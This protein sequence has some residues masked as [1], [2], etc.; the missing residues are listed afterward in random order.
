MDAN[1][2]NV[3]KHAQNDTKHF[4]NEVLSG[5]LSENGEGQDYM[6]NISGYLGDINEEIIDTEN[7]IA[8]NCCGHYKL[9][10]NEEFKTWRPFGRKDYQLLYVAGGSADFYFDEQKVTIEAESLVLFYP[11]EKQVY[12]YRKGSCADVYWVHF[13]GTEVHELL[14]RHHFYPQHVFSISA[15][16]ECILLF[17]RLIREL[18]LKQPEFSAITSL[19]MEMLLLLLSRIVQNTNDIHAQNEIVE[20]AVLYFHTEYQ[21][22]ISIEEYASS[23]GISCCWF[24]R[25]FKQHTGTTPGQYLTGIRINKAIEL[26]NTGTFNIQEAA[27]FVGYENPLYFSRV[28]KKV[29]G[30][31]P[32]NYL[33]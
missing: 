2:K 9:E 7:K 5:I 30:V 23:C 20:Q 32:R 8:V 22:P 18:Q 27:A 11:G 21:S 19:Y 28:F 25:T 13:S 16:K 15:G 3:S 31:S 33:R 10:R 24:I 12:E 26:L 29:M 1:G 17:D 14:K 4:T 6:H